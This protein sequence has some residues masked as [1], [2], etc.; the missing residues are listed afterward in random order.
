MIDRWRL[1]RESILYKNRSMDRYREQQN[2]GLDR[3]LKHIGLGNVCTGDQTL[4]RL[5]RLKMH[6]ETLVEDCNRH[7]VHAHA[8]LENTNR[9]MELCEHVFGIVKVSSSTP[10]RLSRIVAAAEQL[11]RDTKQTSHKRHFGRIDPNVSDRIWMIITTLDIRV[12]D[13]RHGMSRVRAIVEYVHSLKA[14]VHSQLAVLRTD[15]YRN[16]RRSQKWVERYPSRSDLGNGDGSIR[17]LLP[18]LNADYGDLKTA[19]EREKIKAHA[20]VSR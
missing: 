12:P 20:R 11:A 1:L 2:Q 3:I 6:V 16:T 13:I 9:D 15:R 17:G 4:C 8:T 14:S 7:M 19:V 10:V 18:K 5:E